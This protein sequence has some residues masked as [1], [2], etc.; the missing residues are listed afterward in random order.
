MGIPHLSQ[1][2]QT[3]NV[4]GDEIE[5]DIQILIGAV[6]NVY[7]T[8]TDTVV[9]EILNI[10][11]GGDADPTTIYSGGQ[12]VIDS[13]GTDTGAL[14]F[15]GEQD[16]YGIA[17]NATVYSGGLQVVESGG[18]ASGTT[19]SGGTLEL[20]AGA[21]VSGPINFTGTGG[22]LQIDD[23]ASAPGGVQQTDFNAEISGFAVGDVIRVEGFGNFPTIDAATPTFNS[24][25][26]G[27]QR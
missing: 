4:L 8:V 18:T 23:L 14:I 26:N 5:A 15:G 12:E 2:G 13:G 21:I 19:V 9:E 25:S 16:V 10:L 6:V 27:S 7:G 20:Q 17:I 24:S 22:T 3:L 1:S 11:S